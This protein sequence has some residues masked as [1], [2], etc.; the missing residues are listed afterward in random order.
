[1][2]N[3]RVEAPPDTAELEENLRNIRE[4]MS[5]VEQQRKKDKE[6]Y[7]AIEVTCAPLER[8]VEQANQECDKIKYENEKLAVNK[9]KSLATHLNC[10]FFKK[11]ILLKKRLPNIKHFVINWQNI[12]IMKQKPTKL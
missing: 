8:E 5:T 9:N 1:M 11:R 6:E 3:R 7:Q 4:E 10:F 12:Q 2:E